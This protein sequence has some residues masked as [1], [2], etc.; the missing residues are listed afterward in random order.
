MRKALLSLVLLA[1]LAPCGAGAQQGLSVPPSPP[2]LSGYAKSTD[3]AAAVGNATTKQATIPATG[4]GPGQCRQTI[5][6]S[7]LV[8]SAGMTGTPGTCSRILQ[9]GTSA[10]Y[11]VTQFNVGAGC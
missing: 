6:P 11:V 1:A 10:T 3:V 4:P 9:C 7:E 2:D 5:V 8:T